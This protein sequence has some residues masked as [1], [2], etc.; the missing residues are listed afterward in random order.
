MEL[1]GGL[2]D[3]GEML[4]VQLVVVGWIGQAADVILVGGN[5]IFH[6]EKGS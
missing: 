6:R 2:L 3:G 5:V 1:D 4:D